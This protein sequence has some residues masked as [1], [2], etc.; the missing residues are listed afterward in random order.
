MCY[1]LCILNNNFWYHIYWYLPCSKFNM[2]YVKRRFC[3]AVCL[4]LFYAVRLWMMMRI[5]ECTITSLFKSTFRI[6]CDFYCSNF[7]FVDLSS[8][9]FINI[10]V[11]YAILNWDFA[12][13]FIFRLFF[14]AY[15]E[16]KYRK[17]DVIVSLFMTDAIQKQHVS[18]T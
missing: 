8:A 13:L 11:P 18:D 6:S 9:H 7:P 12:I 3:A 16:Q 4:C 17:N 14:F 15:S 10:N 2:L 1:V 5:G